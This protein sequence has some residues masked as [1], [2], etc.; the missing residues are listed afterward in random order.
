MRLLVDCGQHRRAAD[1]RNEV[2]AM[3]SS[4][5]AGGTGG[6]DA[7]ERAGSLGELPGVGGLGPG[8][9][10]G[11]AVMPSMPPA[12]APEAVEVVPE[13]TPIPLGTQLVY[14]SGNIGSG[15]FFAFNNFILPAF[16]DALHMPAIGIG[17]LSSTRSLEG[18]VLQPLVGAWSDRT[19]NRLG[20]RRP[21][22][23]WFVPISV[24]FLLLTPFL[25]GWATD[26][27]LA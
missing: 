12:P 1:E 27:L 2:C 9:E 25:P 18:A 21:F 6:F 17:L 15:I 7:S 11:G 19:W 3:A 4:S 8:F 20:R 26:G 13:P 10:G 16:L 5:D 23:V 22:I 14:S 24:F